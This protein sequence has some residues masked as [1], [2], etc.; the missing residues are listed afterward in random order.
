MYHRST[1]Q[2]ESLKLD[3]EQRW[4]LARLRRV[5]LRN[6]GI[7]LARRQKISTTLQVP[8]KQRLSTAR[9]QTAAATHNAATASL[10]RAW[11]ASLHKIP[12]QHIDSPTRKTQPFA[13]RNRAHRPDTW[14]AAVR[15]LHRAVSSD[16]QGCDFRELPRSRP[17]ASASQD[18]TRVL[19]LHMSTGCHQHNQLVSCEAIWESP[20]ACSCTSGLLH[21]LQTRLINKVDFTLWSFP[22]KQKNEV[23]LGK[24]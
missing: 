23:F 15:S 2:A 21:G 9:Q 24:D 7:L 12:P 10:R 4:C 5:F 11:L 19:H 6:L 8:T 14:P 17:R 1:L 20:G 16:T 13:A 22:A 3:D 18:V